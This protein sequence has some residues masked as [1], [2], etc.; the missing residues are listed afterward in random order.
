VRV[1]VLTS[2]QWKEMS[3]DAHLICFDEVRDPSMERISFALLVV[4]DEKPIAYS[5]VRELDSESVYMQYGGSFHK[6]THSSFKAY[7]LMIQRLKEMGFLRATTLIENKNAVMLK[8][9]MKIGWLIIGCR[10]F[11]GSILLE[12]LIKFSDM[13]V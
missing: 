3:K 13:E 10:F 5:T 6:N 4:D 1:E 2:D 12:H 8:F 7:S 9:A 11:E